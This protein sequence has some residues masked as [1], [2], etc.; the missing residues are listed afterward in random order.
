MSTRNLGFALGYLGKTGKARRGSDFGVL[1]AH[2]EKIA[3]HV[4]ESEAGEVLVRA[5]LVKFA[6]GYQ[7]AAGEHLALGA[8]QTFVAP[9]ATEA[10]GF[11]IA[12]IA[13]SN[14]NDIELIGGAAGDISV[15]IDR[16]AAD[17]WDLFV[18]DTV[19]T[20]TTTDS[21]LP[22]IASGDVV[23]VEFRVEDR[24]AG[25]GDVT[26]T[27]TNLT[28]NTFATGDIDNND[29]FVGAVTFQ[30]FGRTNA[31]DNV[32]A[33][34]FLEAEF[35]VADVPVLAYNFAY[36]GTVDT[37]DFQADATTPANT[38]A[39]VETTA[40]TATQAVAKFTV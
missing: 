29:E 12:F 24:F 8:Q 11:K 18:G 15:R 38:V 23:V 22:A 3:E 33:I 36:E 40:V 28:K 17:D 19:A 30:H 14:A 35:T 4:A 34:T 37:G 1:V 13:H 20:A 9:T 39:T 32:G 27:I 5:D 31:T 7:V 25:D 26:F 10:F 2:M 21:S 6:G 16:T